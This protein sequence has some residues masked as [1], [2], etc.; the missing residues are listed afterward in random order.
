MSKPLDILDLNDLYCEN[1]TCMNIIFEQLY[2]LKVVPKMLSGTGK[3]EIIPVPTWECSSCG[4]IQLS[5]LP[6]PTPKKGKVI[7]FP[8]KKQ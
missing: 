4:T 6:K 7:P 8:S 5:L 3:D 2:T 1:E